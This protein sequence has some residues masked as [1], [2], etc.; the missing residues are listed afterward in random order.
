MI[1]A[2]QDELGVEHL[3]WGMMAGLVLTEE[4]KALARDL[5]LEPMVQV[6]WPCPG[7]SRPSVFLLTFQFPPAVEQGI[8]IRWALPRVDVARVATGTAAVDLALGRA[9]THCLRA[10]RVRRRV[11]QNCFLWRP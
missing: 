9:C 7:C 5:G 6:S 8:D 11:V 3:Q 4:D 2:A 1:W 10:A